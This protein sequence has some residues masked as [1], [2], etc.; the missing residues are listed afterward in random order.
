M[1]FIVK[2]ISDGEADSAN[3]MSYANLDQAVREVTK[4]VFADLL[5][6]NGEPPHLDVTQDEHVATITWEP[7]DGGEYVVCSIAEVGHPDEYGDPDD[8]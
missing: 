7:G 2:R 8:E 5:D 3:E 1:Q 4:E 6:D